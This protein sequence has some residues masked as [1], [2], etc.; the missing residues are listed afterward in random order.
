MMNVNQ[1]MKIDHNYIIMF[2]VGYMK[3]LKIKYK[4][5]KLK[6]K[7]PNIF[8]KFIVTIYYIVKY[9]IV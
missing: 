5:K 3:M 9:I 4:R 1:M 2:L 7:L 6:E 8:K